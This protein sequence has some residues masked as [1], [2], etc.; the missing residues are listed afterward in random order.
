MRTTSLATAAMASIAAIAITVPLAAQGTPPAPP[1]APEAPP[2]AAAPRAP[3]APRPPRAP[4][5]GERVRII[6]RFGDD[7]AMRNRPT[8]GMSLSPTGTVRDTIGVFVMRV[9]PG[10]PA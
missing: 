7:S 4:P 3:E 1:R 2:A 10:G 9:V 6:R 8:L 5:P